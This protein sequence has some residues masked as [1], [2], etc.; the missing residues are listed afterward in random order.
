M[1]LEAVS[2][3]SV[4]GFGE[5]VGCSVF[6]L[7]FVGAGVTG[8]AFRFRNSTI[9]VG[10][11]HTERTYGMTDGTFYIGYLTINK[12][13]ELSSLPGQICGYAPST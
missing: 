5:V 3:L 12:L 6:L 9:F 8:G 10:V 13:L 11:D 2:I 4:G 7:F 1:V